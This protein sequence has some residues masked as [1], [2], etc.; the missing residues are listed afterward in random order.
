MIELADARLITD[1][2]RL[3]AAQVDV[4]AVENWGAVLDHADAHSLTPLLCAAWRG[5]GVWSRIPTAHQDRV[6]RALGDNAKRQANVRAELLEIDSLLTTAGVPHIVLKGWPLAERLYAD[7]AHRVIYDH[8]FLVPADQAEA[9]H[10]ALQAAGFRRL[11]AKDEWIEKHLPS[12]WRNDGYEWDGYLFDPDYPRSVEMHVRLWE[13]RWRGLRVRDLP[14]VWA[15]AQSRNVAGRAMTVL[16]DEDTLIH[17]AMHFAGHLIEREARLNQLLDLARFA[18]DVSWEQIVSR[19]SSAGVARFV[20]AS[21]F[22]AHGIFG[23]PLPPPT[24][25]GELEKETPPR[26]RVWLAEHGARDVLLSDYRHRDKGM[27]YQLTFAAARSIPE[28]LGIARFA[29]LPPA[30]QLMSKYNVGARW[31]AVLLYPR[32]FVERAVSYGRAR[33]AKRAGD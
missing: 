28:R 24:T 30:R 6:E 18:A 13:D 23:S 9:G 27:D 14:D 1:S 5:S 22:L 3:D 4:G 20:Y 21:L 16:S 31:L 10:A 15:W 11:P 12:L 33:A 32:Y 29:I 25:W 7:P 26:F 17:L 2:L 19:S 8:D